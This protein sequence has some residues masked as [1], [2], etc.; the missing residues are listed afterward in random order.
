M[1]AFPCLVRSSS[2]AGEV[3]FALG[4][5]L[6]DSYLEFVAGRA[7]PNTLYAVALIRVDLQEDI[8]HAEG[9]PLSMGDYNLNVLHAGRSRGR[10]PVLAGC[11]PCRCAPAC[12]VPRGLVRCH[13][14][15]RLL[16]VPERRLVDVHRG[17]APP[18][19]PV[20]HLPNSVMG[21]GVPFRRHAAWRL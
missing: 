7:R 19:S 21:S 6:V 17:P 12:V 8:A 15:S 4:D 1:S 13:P 2:P 18:P 9:R 11:S 5:P 10:P 3:R 16:T 14:R 20:R